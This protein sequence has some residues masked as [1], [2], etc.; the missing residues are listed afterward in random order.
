MVKA[1]RA[2]YEVWV[3]PIPAGLEIDHTCHN[4][5]P[6]CRGGTGCVHRRCVNPDH[7][8]AVSHRVNGLRGKSFAAEN[9]R[10]A[11]CKHGHIFTEANT[12]RRP[13]GTRDCRACVRERVRRYKQRKLLAA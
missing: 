1:H 7:L 3:G 12:Y 9:A 4:V 8:E 10:L 13:D 6:Y 11:Q 5:D 2:A